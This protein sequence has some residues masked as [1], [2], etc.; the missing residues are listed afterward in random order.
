[1]AVPISAGRHHP[2]AIG[3]RMDHRTLSRAMTPP[4]VAT[5]GRPGYRPPCASGDREHWGHG[6]AMHAATMA[7]SK[8]K[9]VR[10]CFFIWPL[11]SRY[12]VSVPRR[13]SGCDRSSA[14]G[15]GSSMPRHLEQERRGGGVPA[16][17][18]ASGGRHQPAWMVRSRWGA[19]IRLPQTRRR[20]WGGEQS[21]QYTPMHA[22]RDPAW[23][24][25]SPGPLAIGPEVACSS[26]MVPRR[27]RAIGL[28]LAGL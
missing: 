27:R 16:T 18:R 28:S 4:S 20:R 14:L 11:P 10:S 5:P 3:R 17:G 1:M 25:Q 26:P 15:S 24:F 21:S 23:E 6:S 13:L 7:N 8:T 9:D 2:K 12:A 19:R 22:G